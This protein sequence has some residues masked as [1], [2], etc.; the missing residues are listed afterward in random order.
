MDLANRGIRLSLKNN[1]PNIIVTSKDV[2][3]KAIDEIKN[4]E[5]EVL[6]ALLEEKD[7]WVALYHEES[8]P[9]LKD[10]IKDIIKR[11]YHE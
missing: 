4:N 2:D 10:A 11:R 6:D 5:Q 7:E 9:L 8:S 3:A 1:K